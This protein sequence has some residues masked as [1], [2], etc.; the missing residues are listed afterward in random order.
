MAFIAEC[1]FCHIKLQK[2][3]DY[4]EGSSVECPRCK[5]LFTLT[6]MISPPK[7][8]AS[9]PKIVVPKVAP[10]PAAMPAPAP[11]LTPA[12]L[13]VVP[14]HLEPAPPAPAREMP[15]RVVAAPSIPEVRAVEAHQDSLPRAK[16]VHNV[17]VAA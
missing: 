9:T 16:P 11:V 3:P 10:V 13:P 7:P 14:H 17:G 8:R 12:D 2:V 6:V 1:P 4:R 5:N 15:R